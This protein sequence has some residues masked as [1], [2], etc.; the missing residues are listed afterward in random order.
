MD[1]HE[2]NGSPEDVPRPADAG[3]PAPD[4]PRVERAGLGQP[5][6]PKTQESR[7]WQEE[8]RRHADDRSSGSDESPVNTSEPAQGENSGLTGGLVR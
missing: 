1:A 7:A 2:Q 3:S 4:Q 6:H 5:D 8:L